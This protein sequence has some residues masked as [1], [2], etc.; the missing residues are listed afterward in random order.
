M[1]ERRQGLE[2]HR[3]HQRTIG[4]GEDEELVG[5]RTEELLGPV[6]VGGHHERRAAVG[7]GEHPQD[8]RRRLDDPR[9]LVGVGVQHDEGEVERGRPLPDGANLVVECLEGGVGRYLRCHGPKR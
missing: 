2:L 1:D 3:L 7:F 9:A 5:E 4:V 6:V 8:P